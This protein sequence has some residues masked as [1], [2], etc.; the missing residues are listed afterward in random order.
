MTG[1]PPRYSLVVFKTTFGEISY[2]CQ[3]VL[4]I[5]VLLLR[6]ILN[7]IVLPLLGPWPLGGLLI[8]DPQNLMCVGG[9]HS[10]D[11]GLIVPLSSELD[12]LLDGYEERDL[13]GAK[14]V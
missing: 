7:I 2:I 5:G 8:S 13:C 3:N 14:V 4:T 6:P 12:L 9:R 11:S 1:E 10:A